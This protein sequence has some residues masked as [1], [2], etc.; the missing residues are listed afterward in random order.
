MGDMREM[1]DQQSSVDDE[2]E[3]TE[4][5]ARLNALAAILVSRRKEAV[6]ARAQSGIE[7]IWREDQ[8][9]Y[10][11]IDD[12][13]RSSSAYEKP[14]SMAGRPTFSGPGIES[15]ES[16][17]TV[18][19]NIT[20]PYVDMISARV[21]DML[22][23]TDD[24]PFGLVPTPVAE[25][26]E[27]LSSDEVQVFPDGTQAPAKEIARDIQAKA[28]E[29]AQKSEDRIW[30]WL[31]ESQWHAEVRKVIEDAA[32]IGVGVLKGPM[33]CKRKVKRVDSG[34][35]GEVSIS[36]EKVLAP[37]SKRVSSDD[38]F[39]DPSCGES[40]HNGSY[41]WER[42]YLSEKQ[43]RDLKGSD[44][45]DDQID[46]ALRIG[47]EKNADKKDAPGTKNRFEVWYYHGQI[48]R[49]DMTAA[50]CECDDED[51]PPVNA[52][53]TVVHDQVIKIASA[54][55]DSGE[56]PYDVL[57]WSRKAGHWAGIGVAR[58]VRTPQRMLTAATRTM[59]DNAG[60]SSRPIFFFKRDGIEP[61][62]GKWGLTPGKIY[63]VD[64]DPGK[65]V[66]SSL[67]AFEI[68]NRQAELSAVIQYSLDLAE[69]LSSM[70]LMMQGQQGQATDTVGGMQI[71]Q[72]NAGSVLRRIAKQFDDYITEPHLRRYYE[73]LL[74]YGENADEKGDSMIDARGSSALYERD[75]QN[76]AILQM[77]AIVKDPD[78]GINPE[79]W[80]LEAFKAQKL[81]P[82]RFRY[83]DEEKEKRAAD[84]QQEGAD[85]RVAGQL[86]VAKVRTQG[87]LEKAK[88][89]Q[90]SDM[91]EIE[92]KGQLEAAKLQ[93]QAAENEKQRQHDIAMKRMDYE[94][95]LMEYS[96]QSG[97]NLED[98]KVRLAETSMKLA[99]QKELSDKDRQSRSVTEVSAPPTE[100]AGRADVG[101]SYEE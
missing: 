89:M 21:A 76:Q 42:D 13:N 66:N 85:P 65:S 40:I 94:M 18:F 14:S 39:P 27:Y 82:E 45:L 64:G 77:A 5:L 55:L 99:T 88:L 95:K 48:S 67:F 72:A 23:P 38:L 25:L 1:D 33:P 69:R 51:G 52:I 49:K 57:P 32:R 97:L 41:I 15:G 92:H 75:A 79:K 44:Y 70:P 34:P 7:E 50:G 101:Q 6:D 60:L 93:A 24:R 35:D 2:Q 17:S 74:L 78:F 61:A 63:W 68:P 3:R 29:I 71:L 22:L 59:L 87:E 81:D 62:D 4:A 91:A 19:V 11:G 8:E 43:L 47:P 98:A 58:Q 30:D 73:W 9:F 96:Q 36:I 28:T 54:P 86:E 100:P 90:Q 10:E 16:R 56:F 46:E 20:Q 53:I 26:S 37:N 80:V 12:A 84:Q 31:V 83:T